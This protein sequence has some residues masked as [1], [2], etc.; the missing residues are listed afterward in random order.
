MAKDDTLNDRTVVVG[1]NGYLLPLGALSKEGAHTKSG[2]PVQ[3]LVGIVS[4]PERRRRGNDSLMRVV[5][6]SHK[7]VHYPRWTLCRGAF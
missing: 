6:K 7:H 4:I 2:A 5:C 3:I 1:G